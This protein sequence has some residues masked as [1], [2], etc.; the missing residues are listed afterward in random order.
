MA[1]SALMGGTLAAQ[2]VGGAMSAAGTLAGGNYAAQ[3]GQMEQA[4][5]NYQATQLNQ[6]A[7]QA[8]ASGQRQMLNTQ[9]NTRMAIGASQARS[10]AGG[11]DAG[12]GS[13]AT[14]VGNLAAR[15]SYQ[16]LMDKFNGAATA[17]GLRNQA[18]GV[19]YTGQ[20]EALEGEE[21]QSASEL[22]AAGTIAGSAGSLMSSYGRMEYQSGNNAYRGFA[23]Y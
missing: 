4:A 11:V 5:A 7:A 12:A 18:Q 14:N 19:Q 1:A 21:K 17:T 13:A 3:A 6:N 23:G 16:A 20:M 10:A 9:Q 2:A 8:F 15:G 22:A